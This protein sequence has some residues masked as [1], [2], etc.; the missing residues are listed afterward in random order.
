MSELTQLA[1]QEK[2]QT[3]NFNKLQKTSSP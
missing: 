2:K 1:Q 3:Y